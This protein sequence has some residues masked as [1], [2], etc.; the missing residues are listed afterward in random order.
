MLGAEV[1][2]LDQV[3]NW[4]AFG[5]HVRGNVNDG[6]LLKA[7]RGLTGRLGELRRAGLRAKTAFTV[8]HTYGHVLLQ[9]PAEG[10]L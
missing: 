7:A 4:D 2:F 8:L 3:D 1:R 5:A 10:Q 9:P 6:V